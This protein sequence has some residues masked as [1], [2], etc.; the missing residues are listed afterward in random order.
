LDFLVAVGLIFAIEGLT[1]AAFPGFVQRR[2]RDVM[3]LGEGRMRIA[4]IVSAILGVLLVWIARR[5]LA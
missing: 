2:M 1:F 4:G 3:E 5:L